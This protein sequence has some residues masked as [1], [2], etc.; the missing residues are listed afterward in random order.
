MGRLPEEELTL[1]H[2]SAATNFTAAFMNLSGS[3]KLISLEGRLARTSALKIVFGIQGAV[4]S[5]RA[6]ECTWTRSGVR[7]SKQ[8]DSQGR[9]AIKGARRDGDSSRRFSPG[10]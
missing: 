7:R 8:S 2:A 4:P 9:R 3:A 1:S 10:H 6:F 5:G